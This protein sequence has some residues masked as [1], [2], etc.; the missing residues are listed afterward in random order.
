MRFISTDQLWLRNER[1]LRYLSAATPSTPSTEVLQ[2]FGK[3]HPPFREKLL[4]STGFGF[5]VLKISSPSARITSPSQEQIAKVALSWT[6]PQRVHQRRHSP[7]R[8]TAVPQT[9]VPGSLSGGPGS[10]LIQRRARSFPCT[11]AA[12]GAPSPRTPGR[13]ALPTSPSPLRGT[14][15]AAAAGRRPDPARGA[16]RLPPAPHPGRHP[17][18]PTPGAAERGPAASLPASSAGA[19]GPHAGEARGGG[20]GCGGSRAVGRVPQNPRAA[21]RGGRRPCTLRGGPGP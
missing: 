2:H 10:C 13:G 1:R 14:P 20:G 19:W 17:P 3:S 11:L 8:S 6:Q 15:G 7:R 4:S 18:A 12:G 5:R 16:P 21:R 9:G